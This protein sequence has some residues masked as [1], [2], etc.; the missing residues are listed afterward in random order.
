MKRY[1]LINNSLGWLCFVIAAV[2]YLLTIEPTASFWDCPEFI[3]QGYKLEVGHP[4]GNPIFMLAARFFVNFAFGDVSKVAVMVNSMSALLSAGTILLL[5]WTITHLVKRLTVK[6]DATEIS[7]V[8]MMVIFGSGI[9][10]ALAYTW[11]DTFW[12]SAVEGEVYAFSSFCTAL[13]FWLILK[14]ENRAEQPHS[15]KYL[16]LIAYV[17]GISIAVH[18]LNLLCIPAIGLVIYYRLWKNTTA[19][20]SL[21]TLAFSAIV[22]GLI[23]YGLVP[24]FIEVSQYFE[25]FFVNVIGC[26][27][28][29]GVLIYAIL[30]VS[31]FIWAISELYKQKSVGKIRLS[32][33]LSIFFS[34]IPFIGDN[35]LIPVIIMAGVIAY[36]FLAKKLPVRILN[37]V[38][39]SI[40]VI[41]IGYSSYAL[42]L[43]RASANPPMNQNAPD[44]VFALASYLNREQYGE[45]PLFYGQ[46]HQSRVVYDVKDNG[47]VT[48][49]YK[50]G[51]PIYAKTVKTSEDQPDHYEITGY[52]K[53]YVMAPELN[54][55]FPRIYSGAHAAAYSDWIGGLHG[56][57]VEATKYMRNG[58]P[59]QTE[60]LVKPTM[61][62]SLRFFLVYQLNH[63]YWRYFMWNFAGR[64]ND[65]QGNG[66]VNH[67]NWISGIPF[68]D[69]PRLGDQSL[70][71]Y[72]DG[73]G[74]KGHNVFF[75]LPLIMGIIGLGWQAFTSKRGIEQ[76]WVIFFLFF[77][78]GIAI[79]LYLNQTP[80][81]PRERDYA[82]AGSFYAFAIWVGMGVAGLWALLNELLK[83]KKTAGTGAK[84]Q[85]GTAIFACF[86]GLAVPLQMVSQTWDDHD[87]SGRYVTR[88][89]GMNYL[90]SVDENGIIFTNGDNDTFPLWYA[91]EVEG[92]RTDVKVVNL[93]Y[94][95]TDWYAN[96]VKHPSYEAAGIETLAKPEDYG[97]DRMNF[98]YFSAECDTTPVHIFTALRQLYDKKSSENPWGAP[99]MDYNNF[100]I[101]VDIPAAV[102]AGRISEHEAD[103][104]DTAIQANMTNDREAMRHGGLTLSQVLSLDMLATSVKNGWK[105]PIYF[106]STVPSDYYLALQPYMRSTGMAYE[107]TPVRN[108]ENSD[109]E[110]SAVNTDKAY[111]NITE[112]FRWGGLDKVTDP[113]QIYLD[114]T[115]RK[116]VTTTRSYIISAATGMINE[117]AMAERADS[118]AELDDKARQGL[119][120]FKADRYA[121]ALN[122]L[123]LME[124]KLPEAASPYAIQVPQRMAQIY[125]RI[126]IATGNK[127]A[128]G[129]A[130]ELLENELMR[131]GKNVKYYQ[132]LNPWQYST[133]P[134]TDKFIE[135]YYMVY[136]LQDLSDAGG[137]TEKMVD[138]LTDLGINFDRI[139]SI[140]QK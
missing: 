138:R 71:P 108:D 105:N 87:R 14:W 109:Y 140:L 29:V 36:L 48:P 79:V 86:V 121:K 35:M 31:C 77:M 52:K 17:I 91:Q 120:E 81:Q 130:V 16:I 90:D 27:Y 53:D 59:L 33:I 116:M 51:R 134:Q 74:N 67:G 6:D 15:D 1:N 43:I 76:F 83:D 42:L 112:K 117:A 111:R 104:A 72:S 106:A 75:M 63:M 93:S 100:I 24:G 57:P 96:Q 133:L 119:A 128:S 95:T 22:V 2:T 82:F 4:P 7:L 56:K 44:N 73:E 47:E 129:R 21:I 139:V 80:T 88:D 69:N 137:D 126:G 62:E 61:G 70:L 124:E 110:I 49:M 39:M 8:Q 115:V 103:M 54:M 65:I 19:K 58:Q 20:G 89:F 18:L 13:V 5:F 38:V 97:Y 125:A 102:K 30:A 28:N 113:S 114:E 136:L 34:G 45:R 55:L 23:L 78:T 40:F 98:N 10:G 107:V 127:E 94:L 85:L 41:F 32:V 26:S 25:L 132:S 60:M 122:L 64:Q 50:E 46:T 66:E 101:P 123:K 9:C 3:S 92:H 84:K 118:V 99:M 12:F 68:I 131:Y 135:T 37:L 11:S